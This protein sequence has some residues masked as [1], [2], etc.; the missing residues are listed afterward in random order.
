MDLRGPFSNLPIATDASSFSLLEEWSCRK[1]T[2][3]QEASKEDDKDSTSQKRAQEMAELLVLQ[4]VV[5]ENEAAGLRR[6]TRAQDDPATSSSSKSKKD[7]VEFFVKDNEGQDDILVFPTS[8]SE[9]ELQKEKRHEE[10]Y[11]KLYQAY[12]NSMMSAQE[13]HGSFG[14]YA[15][16][17]F[18]PYLGKVVPI[19]G[20]TEVSWQIRAPFVVPALRWVLRGL[21]Q[22]GHLTAVENMSTDLSSG[23]IMTNDIYYW[24][25]KLQPF[26]F[27]DLKE[28][29]R[30]KRANKPDGEDSEEDIELSEYE[31]LRAERVVRNAERLK[32]LGLA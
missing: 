15:N 2:A 11:S 14:L 13:E 28:L 22:S 4:R 21:I 1:S 29:Q 27:L 24:D 30:R 25:A 20:L 10:Y 5:E 7:A 23:V 8:R 17:S 16:G 31:K 3:V 9:V 32:A 6:S 18:P 12:T 19:A 26:E